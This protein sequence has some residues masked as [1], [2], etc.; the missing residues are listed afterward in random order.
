VARPLFPTALLAG[1]LVLGCG[2]APPVT[3]PAD[4]P[5]PS[6]RAE[7]LIHLEAFQMGGDPRNP[8]AL[9]A[10]F[11]AGV[12]AEDICADPAAQA[13]NGVGQLV[14]TPSGGALVHTSGRDVNLFVYQFG[15][16]PVTG[17]CQLAGAPVVGT[18]TGDFTFNILDTGP[19]AVVVHVSARG[20]IDLVRGG[21]AR[22][23]AT[24]RVTV[25]P[26]GTLLFDEEQVRLTPR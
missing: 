20:T 11:D 18:G 15:A 12:T 9:Q 16:G 21:Q 1:A 23:H 4:P 10:G 25:R 17:P 7:R 6:L 5:A 13:P 24:A 2:D 19:G 8:L 14:L 26:D 3:A 22:L